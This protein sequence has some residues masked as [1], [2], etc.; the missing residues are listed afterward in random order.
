[1]VQEIAS[2]IRRYIHVHPEAA[3]SVDGIHRW[4]LEP[5]L[6]DES[7]HR[8]DTAV[9]RLVAE[10]VLRRVVQ[11]DGRVIYSSGQKPW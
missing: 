9:G 1:M 11:E 8:V 4:W 3:D 2:A 6:R 7:P 10:G 5:A